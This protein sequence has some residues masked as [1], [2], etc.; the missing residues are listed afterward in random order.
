MTSSMKN[1]AEI[2]L[3]ELDRQADLETLHERS[4]G[5]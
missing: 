4:P 2:S 5:R 3:E 1:L